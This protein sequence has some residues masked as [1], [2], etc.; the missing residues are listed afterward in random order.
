MGEE[1]GGR[2]PEPDLYDAEGHVRYGALSGNPRF[3]RGIARLLEGVDRYRIALLC[4]E[5]DPMDCHRRLLVGRVLAYDDIVVLHIRAG[6]EIEAER[7]VA[8]REEALHPERGQLEAFGAEEE[9]WRSIRS[10]S[11]AI[12]RSS[13]SRS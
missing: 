13:S 8:V 2:P 5:E 9:S 3:L 1:L 10:V 7:E 12:A 11:Q 4:S 6:G